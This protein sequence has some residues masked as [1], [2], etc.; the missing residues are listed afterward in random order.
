MIKRLDPITDESLL[1]T[2]F[3]WDAKYPSWFKQSSTVFGANDVNVFLD[4]LRDCI[5]IG[6]FDSELVGLLIL[7]QVIPHHFEA[8]LCAKRGTDLNVLTKGVYQVIRDFLKMGMQEGF[9]LVAEKNLAI[10]KLCGNM[11]MTHDGCCVFKG[12]YRNRV[13]KWMRYS[14]KPEAVQMEQAA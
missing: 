2:A 10:R 9:C 14:I 13:I 6:I 5:L 4:R 1:R 3:E 7:K 11:G 12:T 8:D